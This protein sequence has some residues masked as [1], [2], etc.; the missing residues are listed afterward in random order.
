ME[1]NRD[2]INLAMARKGYTTTQLAE[3]YGISAQRMRIILNSKKVTPATA[4]RLA[5]ALG[6]DVTEILEGVETPAKAP[7]KKFDLFEKF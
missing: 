6:V 2:K 5:A 7:E 3:A 1:L 4:G